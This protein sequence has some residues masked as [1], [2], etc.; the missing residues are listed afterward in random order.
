MCDRMC[1]LPCYSLDVCEDSYDV[2]G[3][4]DPIIVGVEIAVAASED[5]CLHADLCEFRALGDYLRALVEQHGGLPTGQ[6]VE[7]YRVGDNVCTL[8]H[9]QR[10]YGHAEQVPEVEFIDEAARVKLE[11]DALP[12]PLDEL[13][14]LRHAVVWVGREDNPDRLHS[15]TR[16]RPVLGAQFHLRV[17]IPPSLGRGGTPARSV[18]VGVEDVNAHVHTCGAH[19]RQIAPIVSAHRLILGVEVDTG[20]VEPC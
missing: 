4:N 20:N 6:H 18:D 5:R 7:G 19:R 16:P 14:V 3:F 2:D 12:C 10:R 1:L 13:V 9:H 15:D 17:D 11:E 8:D